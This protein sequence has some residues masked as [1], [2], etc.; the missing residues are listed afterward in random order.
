[1]ATKTSNSRPPIVIKEVEANGTTL[2]SIAETSKEAQAIEN[3]GREAYFALRNKWSFYIFLFILAMIGFQCAL[4][5]CIVLGVGVINAS[6]FSSYQPFLYLVV[7]ENFLQIVG[8]GYIVANHLFP[9]KEYV[10]QP[11]PPSKPPKTN[12]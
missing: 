1:M 9:N 12:S 6:N 8:M 11:K 4:T 7:G 3:A 2:S 5:F 10:N